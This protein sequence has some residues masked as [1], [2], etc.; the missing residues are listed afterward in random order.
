MK[1]WWRAVLVAALGAGPV[2]P[3]PAL[4][5]DSSEFWP[6]ASAFVDLREGTR[7]YFDGSIARGKEST[8]RTLDLSAFVDLSIQ[9]I[10]RE[11][12]RTD[13]WQR[14]RYVWA[15]LGYTHVGK[16]DEGQGETT[17][18][19]GVLSIYAKAPLPAEVWI[20]GRARVDLRW[21]GDEF[22]KR[23]R[24]RFDVTR[25]FTLLEHTVV[26]YVNGEAFYDERYDGISRLL[27]QIGTEVTVSKGFRYE[28]YI[29]WLEDRLP[30]ASTLLALG[31]V[32]KWYF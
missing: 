32:A 27:Y 23:Y 30:S 26:P 22:S 31:A 28:I 5:A 13:D 8:L 25:E 1:P 15:R 16:V 21:L 17:E 20:E 18:N 14:A 19:R 9:P 7:L 4:A 10:L 24:L 3:G 12:L 11:D 29:G 6:Q 2:L